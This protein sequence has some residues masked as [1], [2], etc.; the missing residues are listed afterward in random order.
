M[1]RYVVLCTLAVVVLVVTAPAC[2]AVL[3]ADFDNV[4]LGGDAAT[5]GT[6]AADGGSVVIPPPSAPGT[7]WELPGQSQEVR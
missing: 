4:S 6:N 7:R 5:D 1:G 2:A 3:G